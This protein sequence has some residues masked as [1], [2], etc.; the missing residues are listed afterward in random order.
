MRYQISEQTRLG[1]I[2][3]E[4]FVQEGLDSA[5]NIDRESFNFAHP[6]SVFI[7]KWL[8]SALRQLATAQKRLASEVRDRAR[9]GEREARFGEIRRVVS[10]VWRKEADDLASSPPEVV[11]DLP[12]GKEANT[13]SSVETY[14]YPRSVVSA[15]D[16]AQRNKKQQELVEEKVRAIAQILI[17]FGVLDNLPKGKQERLLA[18]IY[19]VIAE[20]N[21]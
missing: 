11:F 7:T 1:Q 8:H 5:L 17:G 6:H 2:T 15:G 9:E 14:V 10:N 16:A 3:C 21:N 12:K 20:D 19:Q 4:V 18:A 13:A